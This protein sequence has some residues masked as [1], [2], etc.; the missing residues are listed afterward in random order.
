MYKREKRGSGASPP[1]HAHVYDTGIYRV[2]INRNPILTMNE[3]C[4]EVDSFYS[5]SLTC[6]FCIE[7]CQLKPLTVSQSRRLCTHQKCKTMLRD[8]ALNPGI[9]SMLLLF[10][11]SNRKTLEA[12]D[13]DK[14]NAASFASGDNKCS[15]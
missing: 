1:T 14:L 13:C 5:V 2:G 3:A 12:G 4:D 10:R 7:K 8:V 15:Y 9:A 11:A 6:T